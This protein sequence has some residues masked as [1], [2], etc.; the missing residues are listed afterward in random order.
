MDINK[1]IDMSIEIVKITSETDKISFKEFIDEVYN[2]YWRIDKE[3]IIN[4]LHGMLDVIHQISFIDDNDLKSVDKNDIDKLRQ[5]VYFINGYIN[6]FVDER[7][8]LMD[9][10]INDPRYEDMTKEEL[11]E[12]LK[13]KDKQ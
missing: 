3:D 2:L 12:L 13:T 4:N 1:T 7:L 6:K 11:I 5:H 9:K 10:H 8:E